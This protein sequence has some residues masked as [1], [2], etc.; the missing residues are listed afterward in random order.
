MTQEI[1]KYKNFEYII[2]KPDGFSEDKKYPMIILLHGAGGRG[3]DISKHLGY[4]LFRLGAEYIKNAVVVMPQCFAD[5]WFDIFEQ[6]KD[7]VVYATENLYADKSRIYVMGASMGAYA[8]W[9]TAMSMPE[10]FAAAVPIC[11]GGMY[12]NAPR[13]KDVPVWAFHG[14]DDPTVLCEESRKMVD[15]VNKHG[16]NA[17]L[18]VFDGVGH[19]A[20]DYTYGNKE[21]F[22]WLF[23][24]HK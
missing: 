7:F 6:L 14:A 20:W 2:A 24:Q 1:C 17:K 5:T 21:M 13:L 9:Q 12:W 11:G 4:P 23:A 16:G 8:T 18:T 22:D 19:N 10:L 3:N 15:A